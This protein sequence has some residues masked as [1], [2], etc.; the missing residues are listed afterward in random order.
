M[1]ISFKYKLLSIF[2]FQF[3]SQYHSFFQK[4]SHFHLVLGFKG[5]YFH[6]PFPLFP[7]NSFILT[8][9]QPL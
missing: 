4:T 7:L 6:E 3:P 5:K 9:F 2:S 1:N 8:P